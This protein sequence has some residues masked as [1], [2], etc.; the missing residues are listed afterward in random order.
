MK[1]WVQKMFQ[2]NRKLLIPSILSVVL[3]LT[4]LLTGCGSRDSNTGSFRSRLIDENGDAIIN[5]KCFS[6]FADDE[7]VYSGL[8]GSFRLSELPAGLNN[9]IIQH[10]E[11]ALE[12]YQVEVKSDQETVIDFIKLDKLSASSR[13]SNVKIGAISSTTVEINWK[14]YKDICCNIHYG[15]TRGY[16]SFVSEERPSQTHYYLLTGLEPEKVYHFKIQ[17]LDEFAN[18]YSSYDYTFRTSSGEA[19]GKPSTIS[20]GNMTE[21]GIVNVSWTA[22]AAAL[23]VAG[24]NLYRK[25]K[26]GSWTRVN[27]N[28]ITG[29]TSYSDA[30]AETG[31][32]CRYAVTALNNQGAESEMTISDLTFIPGVVKNN[33]T[34]TKSDSPVKLSAD[35]II[36]M[37][38]NMIIEAGSEFQ[39]AESD[40]FKSGSDEERVEILVH[41][42]ITIN[43]T[44]NEPVVFTS[45]DGTGKRE[46][47][48]GIRILSSKTGISAI[49]N[50]NLFGCNGYAVSVNSENVALSGLTIKH[51]VGGLRLEN[52]KEIVEIADCY[53]DD[54]ASVAVSINKSF[55]IVLKDS[56]ITNSYIG[57]ENY[58]N[59]YFDQTFV[60]NT[61]IYTTNTGITGIFGNS[62]IVNSLIV[63]PKGIVYKDILKYDGGNILDHN[64]V[65]AKNALTI[66]TGNLT[67]KNNIFVNTLNAGNVGISYNDAL[68]TPTYLHND[69]YGFATA[70]SGCFIGT[71]SVAIDPSFVGGSPF[72]YKLSGTSLLLIN[73]EYKL[74]MGRYGDSRL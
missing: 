74:E 69:I 55:H 33:I 61:D 6:L 63:S 2:T 51:S 18:S 32:F 39:V 52:V 42:A 3:L 72:S 26:D 34:I 66:E 37:G 70:N 44:E 14:T 54:I 49:R 30:E 27:G 9:I 11:Y 65:D 71:D 56:L 4:A 1:T 24:Y 31:V 5:A 17:Y 50:A 40:S 64:T 41:G 60:R 59:S 46:H 29:S 20:L 53:F 19:P 10:S 47:W 15:I 48:A 62:T 68:Y 35:L 36:P 57:V 12:Q 16:G 67:V 8:D 45:L 25:V 73:D 38:I 43:G 13:I 22:P 7:V 28:V 21:L 58:T 23:S